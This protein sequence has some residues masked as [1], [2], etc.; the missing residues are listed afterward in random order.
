MLYRVLIYNFYEFIILHRLAGVM[1][2]PVFVCLLAEQLLKL[3]VDFPEIWSTGRM[4]IRSDS[5]MS[6]PNII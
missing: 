5:L 4:W 3:T 2:Q 6:V 1:F